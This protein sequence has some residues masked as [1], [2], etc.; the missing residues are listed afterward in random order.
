MRGVESHGF[1]RLY[2]YY[3]HRV[4]KGLVNT[5]RRCR[6]SMIQAA[7]LALDADNGLGQP[8]GYRAMQRCIEK[9]K[10]AARR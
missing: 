10:R 2:P 6:W 3:Y 5:G 7:T 4:K 8:S 9:Q 1:H